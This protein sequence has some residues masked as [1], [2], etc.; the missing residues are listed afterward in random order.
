MKVRPTLTLASTFT[1]AGGFATIGGQV[2]QGGTVALVNNGL[3]T[4]NV[5]G[6]TLTIQP[7]GGFT[8][9]G[10]IRAG[11]GSVLAINTY[12]QT[13]SG[14]AAIDIGGLA[15]NQFGRIAVT[16]VSNLNGTLQLRLVNG[17][18]PTLGQTFAVLTYGSRNGQF[19]TIV[20]QDAVDGIGYSPTYNATNLTLTAVVG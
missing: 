19:T 8:N 10:L 17:F 16:G 20:D 2:E 12:T 13:A 3:I 11:S 7:N 6:L 4:A 1:I 18:V 9:A 5:S 14:I 15:A